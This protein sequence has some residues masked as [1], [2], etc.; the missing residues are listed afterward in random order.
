MLRQAA[1][2]QESELC[3]ADRRPWPGPET[4]LPMRFPA[5]QSRDFILFTVGNFF[6]LNALWVNRV[7]IGWL[8]WEL[9]GL[10]SWVGILSFVLF[11]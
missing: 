10:A 8:A 6:G 3:G 5:F 1:K 7:V 9:T 2:D 4:F 11:A